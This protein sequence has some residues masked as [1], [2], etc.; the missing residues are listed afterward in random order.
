VILVGSTSVGKTSLINAYFDQPFES[1]VQATVAP[2]FCAATV[3]LADHT[4][5]ELHVWDTA[6]QE[7]FQ[8]IGSMF[9]RDSDIAFVCFESSTINSISGWVERVRKEVPDCFVFLVATKTDLLSGD[10]ITNLELSAQDLVAELRAKQFCKT[11]AKDGKGVRELFVAAGELVS[12]ICAPAAPATVLRT[13][14][15]Q[16]KKSGGCC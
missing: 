6:G 4:E 8:S 1:E 16:E 5:V 2:A 12:E 3:K 11:S 15:R 7:R 14:T 9:Y 10:E 13:P